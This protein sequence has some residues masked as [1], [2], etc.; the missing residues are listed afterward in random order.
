MARITV[1]NDNAEFLDLMHDLLAGDRHETVLIDGDRPTA[2][3]EIRASRPE[4]LI[5][6]I[7]LGVIGDHGWQIA[8]EVRTDPAHADLPI[9]LCCSDPLALREMGD[10][11]GATHRVETLPKPFSLDELTEK[12]DRL[13]GNAAAR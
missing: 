13:I 1:V 4:L 3:Q 11:I 7:R 9:L 2:I 5:I 6:D 10:E 8:K 12:I